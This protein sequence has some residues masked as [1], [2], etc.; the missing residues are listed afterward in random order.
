MISTMNKEPIGVLLSDVHFGLNTLEEAAQSY[1]YAQ[2]KAAW[3]KVPLFIT[4]DLLDTKAIIRAEVA[5][6]LLQLV[7]AQDAPETIILCGN[8]DLCNEKSKEH[9]LNFLRPFATIVDNA[10]TFWIK[11][12]NILMI[13]YQTDPKH[14]RDIITDEDLYADIVFMHQ[15]LQG[16]LPGEYI[17]DKS[18]ISKTE[19]AGFRIISGHYHERQ[20]IDLPNGGLW[21]YLGN[22][23]TLGFGEANH[24]DKGYHILYS[25][26]SL[27]FIPTNL[28]RHKVIELNLD[29][30][31]Y[32]DPSKHETDIIWI[33]AKSSDPNKLNRDYI[34][35]IVR[36][37]YA[38]RLELINTALE[39]V[40]DTKTST[41]TQ[42]L[43]EFI[44]SSNID[45]AQKIRLKE[46]WKILQ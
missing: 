22:P 38:Y 25:D 40:K 43:D 35:K 4:G 24:P 44:D 28:R 13:P 15:G 46:F 33:K 9:A 41:K 31:I 8:H 2:F 14:I 45:A 30:E 10:R 20:D 34:D 37:K 17:N 32:F 39:S 19:V 1:L 16:A 5:N 11:G 7:S 6:R 18:S 36:L 29:G 12:K 27:E 21:T 3:L 42:S 26:L 23:Y